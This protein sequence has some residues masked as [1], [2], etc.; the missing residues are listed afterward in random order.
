MPTHVP[1]TAGTDAPGAMA[2]PIPGSSRFTRVNCSATVLLVA[3][4]AGPLV[5]AASVTVPAGRVSVRVPSAGVPAFATVTVYG[6]APEPVTPVALQ[7]GEV[8]PVVKSPAVR[9]VTG[10]SKVTEKVVLAVLTSGAAGVMADTTGAERSTVVDVPAV[11]AV[12]GNAAPST[13]TAPGF[14][15]RV[16]VPVPVTAPPTVT[17]YGPAPDPVS[18]CTPQPV[19]VPPTV[20]S[21]AARP[22]GVLWNITVKVVVLALV[23]AESALNASSTG[24]VAG[25]P[26]IARDATASDPRAF[27]AVTR[28]RM[29]RPVSPA[30]TVYDAVVAPAPVP[31][32]QFR[33]SAEVSH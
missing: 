14:M 21:L 12:A 24:M 32:A 17:V 10:S 13:T 11:V 4:P 15:L 23:L 6:P 18:D 20:K 5:P 7:P 33:P 1:V 8:P 26:V 27:V 16:T 30:P 28:A 25:L 2:A 9:P 22:V 3:A 31:S 29:R 19:A